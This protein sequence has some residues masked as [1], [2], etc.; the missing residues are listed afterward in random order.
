MRYV[1][2]EVVNTDELH[3][4]LW[5]HVGVAT[6]YLYDGVHGY[7]YRFYGKRKQ[8]EQFVLMYWTDD[9]NVLELE[10]HTFHKCTTGVH[11]KGKH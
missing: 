1:D 10:H 9:R 6:Q 2:L 3:K 11:K 4:M 5:V 8:L 7:M